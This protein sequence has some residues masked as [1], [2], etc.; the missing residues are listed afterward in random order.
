MELWIIL[1]IIPA[2]LWAIVNVIDK[3]VLTN[4][5]RT[6][7]IPITV[8]GII[9][10]LTSGVIYITK[11]FGALS[12]TNIF[13]SLVAGAF[14]LLLVFFYFKAMQIEDASRVIPLFYLNVIL[15][16]VVAAAF[17]GEVFTFS[18]YVGIVLMII[19]ALLISSRSISKISVG[20]AFWLMMLAV[21]FSAA[22][23]I[24]TKYLLDF[25]DFW[26]IFSYGRI[27]FFVAA[28]PLFYLGISELVNITKN[29][30]RTIAIITTSEL[31]GTVG[32]VSIT[33]ATAIGYVT[34]VN[35]ISSLQ[36]F[37]LL[38][39]TVLISTFF[40]KILKEETSKKTVLQKLFAI[41]M[42]LSGALLIA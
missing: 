38:V 20:K 42:I 9:G 31:L 32:S 13:L 23:N 1:S 28:I 24:L 5:V 39:L 25:T 26:T 2:M 16:A 15:I 22:N 18:A 30:K 33:A 36:P 4:C 27:G 7:N 8:L 6:P 35:A 11:G 21:I 40:P 34:L 12:Y 29:K 10:M 37:F 3:Y 19:G 14:Y 41:A 17:L